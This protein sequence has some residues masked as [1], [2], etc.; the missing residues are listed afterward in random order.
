MTLKKR[1]LI[2]SL[3]FVISAASFANDEDLKIKSDVQDVNYEKNTMHFKGNV[4]V[5]QG[6]ISIIAEDLLVET[7]NAEGQKLL[8]K[9]SPARFTQIDDVNGDLS[10]K[11]LQIE[12][13]VDR[14]ILRLIG[15]AKFQQG[16]SE[17]QSGTIEFDL[18][19]KRVKADGDV[20]S[21]GRVTTTIKTKKKTGDSQ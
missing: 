1:W 14:Q 18:A 3:L 10:A 16:G 4:I 13:F 2:S 17:V 7:E 9:G 21:G 15:D 8:A 5:T 12:Y 20:N 19:K 11:A 6:N